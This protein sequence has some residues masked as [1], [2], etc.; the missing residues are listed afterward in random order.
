M[1]IVHFNDIGTRFEVTCKDQDG[2]EITELADASVLKIVFERPS[3]NSFER[4]ADYMAD[5]IIT[6]VTV[7]G[8]LNEVGKWKGQGYV[9]FE[10][11]KGH[12]SIFEFEVKRVLG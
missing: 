8:D 11:Y 10:D 6:Y 2:R 12:S 9:E 7:S 3:G 5:G 4:V 1:R